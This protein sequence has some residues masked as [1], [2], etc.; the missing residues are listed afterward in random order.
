[1]SRPRHSGVRRPPS[2]TSLTPESKEGPGPAQQT[3]PS[4][5]RKDSRVSD[6][7]Q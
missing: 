3:G 4:P 2:R 6:Q 1:M 5:L 7:G